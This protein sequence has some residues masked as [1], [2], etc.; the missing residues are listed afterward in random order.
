MQYIQFCTN[1]TRARNVLEFATGAMIRKVQK[2]PVGTSDLYNSPPLVVLNNFAS[3]TEDNESWPKYSGLLATTFQA[4]FPSIDVSTVKLKDCR[5]VLL[6]NFN[7]ASEL[8][9]IRHY[10]VKA[11]PIDASRTVKKLIKA[12]VPNLRECV[13]VAEVIES[14]LS[15]DNDGGAT[16]DSEGEDATVSLSGNFGVGNR[17]GKRSAVK[18][19]EL[20]PRL[21]LK[22]L[23]VEDGLFEG[24]TTYHRFQTRTEAE[25]SAQR[26]QVEE[27]KK[28]LEERR[29]I[30]QE[31]VERKR[32]KEEERAERKKAKTE[33]R[34][35]RLKQLG[36]GAEE[37]EKEEK[38]ILVEERKAPKAGV[39]R[40]KRND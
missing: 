4:M 6:V 31:N 18:L 32:K 40:V 19:V 21:C 26:Q 9:D 35:Q 37:E 24:E 12:R 13:D 39:K 33:E 3:P 10:Y 25:V 28:L 22:L 15:F 30:Q 14:K 5:R 23:K 1:Y 34:L 36:A 11:E 38:E 8:V 27:G 7:E 17:K 2:K 20:G 16:S 29:R